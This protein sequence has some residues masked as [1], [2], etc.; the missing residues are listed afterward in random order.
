MA[1][2]SLVIAL[3]LRLSAKSLTLTHNAIQ[4]VLGLGTIAIGVALMHEVGGRL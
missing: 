3:P 2:L 4:G 1:A